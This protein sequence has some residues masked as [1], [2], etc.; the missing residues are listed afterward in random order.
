MVI[1]INLFISKSCCV[2]EIC[3]LC[4]KDIN[5]THCTI[6]KTNTLIPE[7]KF[8]IREYFKDILRVDLPRCPCITNGN[9][10]GMQCMNKIYPPYNTCMVHQKIYKYKN[11]SNKI[12]EYLIFNIKIKSNKT[13]DYLVLFYYIFENYNINENYNAN[14]KHLWDLIITNFTY[15]KQQIGN[16][17]NNKNIINI[18]NIIDNNS[19]K[20][21]IL[22]C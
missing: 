15:K 1:K 11:I 10:R 6:C 5:I 17:L 22:I 9:R 3:F 8:T 2:Y 4:F 21:D 7:V 12:M 19:L 16:L 14:N 18:T 13:V 20:N